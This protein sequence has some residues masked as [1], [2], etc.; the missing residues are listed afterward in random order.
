MSDG[1]N[2]QPK[3]TFLEKWHFTVTAV[4]AIATA[5][6]QLQLSQQERILK[7]Q[8]AAIQRSEES[9]KQHESDAELT[10]K[11]YEEVKSALLAEKDAEKR[12]GIAL[13]LV[14]ELA[15]DS[16]KT[17]FITVIRDSTPIPVIKERASTA[18][19]D[20]ESK[21][22]KTRDIQVT[23]QNE[24]ATLTQTGWSNWDFD[25]FWCESSGDKARREANDALAIKDD[26]ARGRWR[27]RMLPKSINVLPGYR[28]SG[29]QI[30][31]NQDELGMG[32]RL[33]ENLSKIT[34]NGRNFET[35]PV[36]TPTP[37]YVSVFF[38]PAS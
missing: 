23:T 12:Q 36:S 3:K 38:C 22:L 24:R 26:S 32:K 30:R 27:I 28:I 31:I 20:S 10:F 33:K 8:A 15:S 6:S 13:K 2:I 21:D 5:F 18:A 35:Y 29:Y 9:R 4:L 17:R 34:P 19:Y 37:Y 1:L 14:E 25:F 16:F 7:E 11:L